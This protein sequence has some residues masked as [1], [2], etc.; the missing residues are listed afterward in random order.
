[1]GKTLAS[2]RK[3]RHEYHIKETIEAGMVLTGTEV[4]SIRNG[5]INIGE[6]YGMIENGEIYLYNV[7]ISPYEQ[8]NRENVDPLR[9][10]KL[11]FHRREILKLQNEIMQKGRTL[12]PLSVYLNN[13]GIVKISI[14][15]AEGKKL[16]DKRQYIAKKDAER[17][18]RQHTSEKYNY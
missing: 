11:L 14:G 7:H 18:M 6:G 16:F 4:K 8:G 1:M 9:K 5:R 3:A 10:R 2:N 13:R 15:L 17:R 12:V